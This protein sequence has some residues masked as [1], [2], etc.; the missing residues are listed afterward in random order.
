MKAIMRPLAMR[1]QGHCTYT[2]RLYRFSDSFIHESVTLYPCTCRLEKAVH[3]WKSDPADSSRFKLG[4]LSDWFQ[5]LHKAMTPAPQSTVS[6]HYILLCNNHTLRCKPLFFIF[7]IF[8]KIHMTTLPPKNRRKTSKTSKT[9]FYKLPG[10][11]ISQI[12]KLQ[13]N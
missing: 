4:V 1:T 12:N 13:K 2:Y 5:M 9:M 11:G 6:E 3:S 7:S 10:A 8:H